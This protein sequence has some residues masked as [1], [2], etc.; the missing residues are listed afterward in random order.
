MLR[1]TIDFILKQY[2]VTFWPHFPHVNVISSVTLKF[3]TRIS[4]KYAI[5]VSKTASF[6]TD[7]YLIIGTNGRLQKSYRF[8]A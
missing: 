7:V 8:S 5:I 4:I 1:N 2:M 6:W 3:N